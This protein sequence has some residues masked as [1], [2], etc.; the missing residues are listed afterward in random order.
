MHPARIVPDG[1]APPLPPL[2]NPTPRGVSRRLDSRENGQ[3]ARKEGC[4]IASNGAKAD[5]RSRPL[6]ASSS[7]FDETAEAV[8]LPMGAGW[9]YA[10]ARP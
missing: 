6:L 1:S 2:S 7:H 9:D 4:R 8:S 10:E 5:G 3:M